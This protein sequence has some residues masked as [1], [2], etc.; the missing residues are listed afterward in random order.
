MS[1]TTEIPDLKFSVLNERKMIVLQVQITP[2]KSFTF[3]ILFFFFHLTGTDRRLGFTV[4][5]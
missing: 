3:Y 1:D 5:P 2:F 4:E